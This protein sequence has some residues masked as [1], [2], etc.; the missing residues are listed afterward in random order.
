MTTVAALEAAGLT[1]SDNCTTDANLVV[2]SV[3]GTASGTCPITFTRTYTIKDACNNAT[4]VTQTISINDSIIPVVTSPVGSLD[5]TLE[6]S[7]ASAIS[8]ALASEPVATDNC[9]SLLQ[10][11]LISDTT[12]VSTL[13][14]NTYIRTRVWNFTDGCSNLS[15]NFTQII[16]IQDNTKPT[17]TGQLPQNLTLE[18][19]QIVPSAAV[20]TATDNCVGI[21]TIDFEEDTIPG[22]CPN[23]ST[24]LRTWTA[25]DDCGNFESHTQTITIEDNTPPTFDQE[26]RTPELY[27]KCDAI[28]APQE[29]SAIDLCG[30][31]TIS[32]SEVNI[33]GDCTN[34]Y[35][36]DRTWRATDLCGNFREITQSVYLACDVEVFNAVSPDGDGLNDTFIIEGLECYP[37]NTVEIY[38]RW[39]VKVYETSSYDN[40]ANAFKGFSDGRTTLSRSEKLP[41]GT[42]WYILKYEYDLYGLEKENKQKIG[43]LYIQNE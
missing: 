19:N 2:T 23:N 35:R 4:T 38:N 1:I 20:L 3:D 41:T 32:Y 13:C 7:N 30:T 39:G 42:Y 34:K 28:P 31:A 12:S 5:V 24:I 11:H 15:S 18:C 10:I 37:N 14:A 29:F 22:T 25:T 36:I 9:A 33:A 21:V 40:F 43:Y 16:T 26:I 8:A 27:A 6:C 17:F